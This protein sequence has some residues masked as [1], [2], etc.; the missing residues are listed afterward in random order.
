M[1]PQY[2]RMVLT[3]A[4]VL[5]SC[6]S[7][8][9]AQEQQPSDPSQSTDPN[10]PI[11][12]APTQAPDDS[13]RQLPA[14]AGRGPL[15]SAGSQADSGQIQPDS[16]MLS[17]VE[18][19]GFGT[20]DARPHVVDVVLG[21]S[22]SV[23]TGIVT[24][25]INSVTSFNQG[26]TYERLEPPY[27][28]TAAY[29]GSEAFYHPSTFFNQFSEGGTLAQEVQWKRWILRLRD[30]L[31][32]SREATFGN[33]FTGSAG[34]ASQTLA[35]T[36]VEP[37]LS[38]SETILTGTATRLSNTATGE[39][40]YSPSRRSTLTFAGSYGLLHFFDPTLVGTNSFDGRVGYD[41]ALGA[42]NSIGI[43]Y[44]YNFTDFSATPSQLQ[45]HWFQL[46][47]GR[48]ITGRFAFQISGGPQLLR[49]SNFG[50]VSGQHWSWGLS[51]ALSY[52]MTRATGYSLSYFHAVTSGSGVF[53]GAESDVATGVATHQFTRVWSA[54]VNGGYARNINAAPSPMLSN[55]FDNWFAGA[56][57]GRKLGREFVFGLS[58]TFQQQTNSVGQCP[59]VN[60][61]LA[62]GPARHFAS[63]SL[64]WHPLGI[65]RE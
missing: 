16:H 26:V 11:A 41:L 17:G 27:R 61:G 19:M 44:D 13:G 36:S 8:V 57:V 33:L 47:F 38:P 46:A 31:V 37:T 32:L 30:D 35:L 15:L 62:G 58:Y 7:G 59:V 65:Q 23:D 43:I 14:A 64:Q 40:D 24:G 9:R 22:E 60:C 39:L 3:T 1:K 21:A 6:I 29:Q 49:L 53:F 10:A 55:R 18:L 54:S 2:I 25:A 4:F 50:P 51:G 48:K 34:L 5:T 52:Q 45:T 42:K 12:P 28:F 63:V 56:T 20:L